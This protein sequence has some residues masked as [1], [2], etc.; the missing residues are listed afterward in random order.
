MV[1]VKRNRKRKPILHSVNKDCKVLTR[2][3]IKFYKNK[4]ITV[5]RD[6][7]GFVKGWHPGEYKLE[8]YVENSNKSYTFKPI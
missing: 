8:N 3:L 1:K 2:E 4:Y 5:L 6:I 7:N